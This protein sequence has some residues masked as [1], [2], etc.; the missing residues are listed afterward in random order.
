MT[1]DH[2][3]WEVIGVRIGSRKNYCA[4]G[5]RTCAESAVGEGEL[6]SLAANAALEHSTLSGAR[7]KTTCPAIRARL[8]TLLADALQAQ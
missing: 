7:T 5:C 1:E 3:M 8:L 2:A 6:P 4:V